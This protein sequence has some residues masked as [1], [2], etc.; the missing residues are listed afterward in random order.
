MKLLVILVAGASLSQASVII[1]NTAGSPNTLTEY[2]GESFTTPSGGPWV[3]VAFNFYSNV[4]VVPPTPSAAGTAFLL[5]QTFS[6]L[7]TALSNSVPGFVAAST[8]VSGGQY[9][10][11]PSV[12]LLSMTTYYV[13]ENGSVTVEGGS[14]TSAGT[15]YFAPPTDDFQT[16]IGPSQTTDFAVTASAAAAVPEPTT[17]ELA[18]AGLG[19]IAV[20]SLLRRKS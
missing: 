5:T 17:V 16:A 20:A 14:A 2:F 4:S 3:N 8:G 19:L 15:A 6:G 12:E 7:P 18:L 11:A 13:Y 1:Q 9:I 10:F